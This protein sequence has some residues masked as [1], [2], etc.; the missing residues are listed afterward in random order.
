MRN[1]L[2]FDFA[3]SLR[4]IER[5]APLAAE[6]SPVRLSVRQPASRGGGAWE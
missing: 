6:Q 4:V 3:C 2:L 1:V 5:Q